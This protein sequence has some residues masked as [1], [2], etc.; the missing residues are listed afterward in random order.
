MAQ[1]IDLSQF[2]SIFFEEC[3]E[4][5][6]AM[7]SGLL[8]LGEGETDTEMINTIFRAAHSIKGGAETFGFNDISNFTHSM[9]TML[10]EMREGRRSVTKHAITLL[11]ERVDCLKEMILCS[12]D[13]KEADSVAIANLKQQ[14]ATLPAEEPEPETDIRSNTEAESQI[15][16]AGWCVSFHPL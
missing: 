9:E 13:N 12:K 3:S 1:E 8:K 2:H 4:G 16:Y 15:A 5:I 10:D 6:A 11:L 7:E 14:L